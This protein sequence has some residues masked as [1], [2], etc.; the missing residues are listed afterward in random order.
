MEQKTIGVIGLGHVGLVAAAGF[1][2]IGHQ[3]IGADTD[4]EKVSLIRSG[5]VPFYEPELEGLI[6]KNLLNGRLT[7]SE[8]V[9]S[10][11]KAAGIIF[12]CVGTPPKPEGYPDMSQLEAAIR[13]IAEN[14]DGYKLI[15]E[16]ST[17]PVST[18]K[19]IKMTI[20]Q[21]S[22]TNARF[23]VACNPEF[24]RE[25]SA[26]YDF[27]HPYRIVIGVENERARSLLS[28]IYKP[29]NA[30]LVVTDPTTAEIIKH[31][32]NSF[33]AMK[34]SFINM[35]G[36]LCDVVGGDVSNVARALGF[37]P[38]IGAAFLNAG[39]GFGGSCLPKDLRAFIHTGRSFGLNFALLEEVDRI[40]RDRIDRCVD[41]LR[42]ALGSL[43][44]KTVA[45]WGLSFKPNTDDVRETPA[46][47][48]V[49]R[50][51]DEG[52]YLRLYDPASIDNFKVFFPENPPAVRYLSTAHQAATGSHAI[53]ILTEWPEF[54][55]Q[56]WSNIRRLVASPIVVDG[57]NCLDP[58]EL[59]RLGFVYYGMGK[60][61]RRVPVAQ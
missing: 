45:V 32:A 55:N 24:L 43:R 5:K 40:N 16:K 15:V 31:A 50:L 2:E 53:V 4:S 28:D 51:L 18:W 21:W 7:V 13:T 57:R 14:L 6:R 3:I 36:D 58:N 11:I 8:D 30:P 46:L 48:A 42:S 35:V 34:I 47:K 25:G 61:G 26:V 19:W 54:V 56:S 38:R 59:E 37:D 1:A 39:V 23:D 44:D 9:G 52:A 29:L 41:K 20:E 22:G 33:L 27:F 17:V 49:E 60:S 10:A 12:I